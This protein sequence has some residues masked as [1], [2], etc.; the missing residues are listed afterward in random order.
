MP[1]NYERKEGV[2]AREPIPP[3]ILKVAVERALQELWRRPPPHCEP[4]AE[5]SHRRV[6]RPE[7]LPTSAY[8][9]GRRVVSSPLWQRNE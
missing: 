6:L 9:T 8:S 4:L 7:D 3:D 2:R 1:Q 5:P